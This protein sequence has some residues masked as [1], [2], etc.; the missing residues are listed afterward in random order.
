VYSG[1]GLTS[2]PIFGIQRG[3]N[4]IRLPSWC[5]YFCKCL[6]SIL[7]AGSS[8]LVS[9]VS[10]PRFVFIFWLCCVF[11]R[12]ASYLRTLYYLRSFNVMGFG[13]KF[14]DI[15]RKCTGKLFTIQRSLYFCIEMYQLL[16]GGFRT[17][18]APHFAGSSLACDRPA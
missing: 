3:M 2:F 5:F 1:S 17:L 14:C 12:V 13:C 10:Y 16:N 7:G 6:P 15:D 8:W 4:I 18:H 11:T 9:L